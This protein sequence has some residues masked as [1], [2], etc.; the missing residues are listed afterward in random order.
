VAVRA[1]VVYDTS[2]KEVPSVAE[3]APRRKKKWVTDVWLLRKAEP[4]AALN[5]AAT[6]VESTTPL[7]EMPLIPVKVETPEHPLTSAHSEACPS[8]TSRSR[9][10]FEEAFLAKKTQEETSPGVALE[11]VPSTVVTVDP[12]DGV[13]KVQPLPLKD[14]GLE[15][16]MPLA[17]PIPVAA[18]MVQGP[19]G[20][21]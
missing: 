20:A 6:V 18:T 13:E 7:A 15:S 16:E 12:P 17:T 21:P 4:P 1:Q 5:A 10:A 9:I 14:A 19:P 3:L 8:L 11:G 2:Q